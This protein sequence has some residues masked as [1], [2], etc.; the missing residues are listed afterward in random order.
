MDQYDEQLVQV[1]VMQRQIP[2]LAQRMLEG[3]EKYVNLDTPFHIEERKQRLDLVRASLSNP[4]VT[5]SEQVRQILEAYNIEAEY[6]RKLDAYDETIVLDGQ[7]VVVNILRVGRLG[8]FFQ[9]KDERKTGYYDNETATWEELPGSYR[10]TVRD[11]IRMAQKL[12]PMDIM[13]L[14]VVYRG[15]AS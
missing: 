15:D 9:S 6:G 13:M 12:A 8:M 3:L 5:A 1:V 10:V 11:G 4:K 2:P 14:P 7:E